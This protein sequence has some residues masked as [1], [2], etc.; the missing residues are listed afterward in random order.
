MKAVYYLYL[1]F[2]SSIAFLPFRLLYVLSDLLYFIVYKICRYRVPIVRAN[3]SASFPDMSGRRLEDVEREFYHHFCDN[4]VETIKLL[5]VSDREINRRVEVCGAGIVESMA[6]EGRPIVVFLGHYG[7]WEWVPAVTMHFE[8]PEINAQIYRPL[9]DKAFDRLML[10]VRSRFNSIS[11]P[12]KKA[13]RAMLRMCARH[14]TFL[15]GFISDQHPNSSVMRHWTDFLGQDTA[16]SA[17]GEEIGD[18]I[19]AGYVYLDVE[20]K[21]R[22]HYLMTF[23]EMTPRHDN[24]PCPYTR[25]YMKM[26]ERTIRRQPAF[27]LWTHRRWLYKRFPAT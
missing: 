14:G 26:L 19:G 17:G 2:F 18:R 13:F 25:L 22:G 5:H 16:Y 7:N 12:Q 6:A 15:V 20:K 8:K 11:I 1:A 23:V 4:I 24:E 21:G 9:R 10:K 3:L 27:W